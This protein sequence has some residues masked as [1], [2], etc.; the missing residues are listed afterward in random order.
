MQNEKF[1]KLIPLGG[2]KVSMLTHAYPHKPLKKI[3]GPS[4]SPD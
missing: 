4:A 3:K 1:T 2:G